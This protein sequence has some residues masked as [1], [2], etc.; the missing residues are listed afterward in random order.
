MLVWIP[1]IA[2]KAV[3]GV[4]GLF[5]MPLMY[6]YRYTDLEHIPPFLKLFANPEDW[7]GGHN[8]YHGSVPPWF[9]EKMGNRSDFWKFYKYHAIRNPTDGLRNVK[10]L[11]LWI[12]PEKVHYWTPELYRHYS[13]WWIDRNFTGV[14]GYIA[15]QGLKMGLKVQWYRKDSYS[16]VKFGFRVEPNDAHEPLPIKSARRMYGASFAN[17]VL[18]N[19]KR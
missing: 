10:W 12:N 3:F 17:K 19:R 11:Q 18:I 7:T 2:L 9:R 6:K 4:L 5:V 16:E 13:S 1:Q 8:N 15:W 14:I